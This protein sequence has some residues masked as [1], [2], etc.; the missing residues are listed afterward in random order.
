MTRHGSLMGTPGF[1]CPRS[2]RVCVLWF[3]GPWIS[4][5]I[6]VDMAPSLHLHLGWL[7]LSCGRLR[8]HDR[9]GWQI[10]KRESE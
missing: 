5:G 2:W 3:A 7:V 4:L 10:P 6:H 1:W 8:D 9:E